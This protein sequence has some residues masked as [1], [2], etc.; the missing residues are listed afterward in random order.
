MNFWK[1][2]K[3]PIVGLAPMDGI[4]DYPM[5]EIQS[6]ISKPDVMYTEFISV[7][8]F[9][10]VPGKFK[11]KLK[12]SEKER[13]IVVQLFGHT[14][15]DFKT[16]VDLVLQHKFDGID[17]NM[18]CPAR[19]VT[20]GGGGAGLIGN[21]KLTEKIIL[22]CL[23]ITQK[24]NIPLS[25]KTRIGIDKPVTKEW[26]EFLCQFK[27]ACIAV[28]GRLLKQ[29]HS[30][31]IN[32]EEIQLAAEIAHQKDIPLLGNGGIKS[33]EQAQQICKK[34]KLDG[35]L[36]GQAARGNPWVF[37]K[38]YTPTTKDKFNMIIKHAK[39]AEEFYGKKGFV[40]IRKHLAW[41]C[42][43]IPNSKELRVKLVKVSNSRE[44]EK[45]VPT[46]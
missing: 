14:T 42:K 17:I 18:G 36:I 32:W 41:Y 45:I 29:V 43:G 26:M 25:V 7:E 8:G 13:P 15:E 39:L 38:E 21:Y 46:L 16:A 23:E 37:K 5:R 20:H 27:L 30:G 12:Y 31:D 44:V 9:S 3:K 35:V 10:R 2:L 33:I 34:Y 11:Q 1:K 22:S 40:S 19:N 24:H 4:T 6:E 28:H